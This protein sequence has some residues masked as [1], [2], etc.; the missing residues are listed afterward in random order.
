MKEGYRDKEEYVP[1]FS[2]EMPCEFLFENTKYSAILEIILREAPD[3]S[4]CCCCKKEISKK[5]PSE[6][7]WSCVQIAGLKILT[8]K[9]IEDVPFQMHPRNVRFQEIKRHIISKLNNKDAPIIYCQNLKCFPDFD[10]FLSD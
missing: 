5:V 9:N 1:E 2:I 7:P 10:K 6:E 3:R 4:L 8:L